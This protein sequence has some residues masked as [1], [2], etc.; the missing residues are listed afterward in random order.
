MVYLYTT[1]KVT[2]LLRLNKLVERLKNISVQ[3]YFPRLPT[4]EN[5][6]I[7]C[8][9]DAS[10]RNLPNEGSQAGFIIF[11]E[12]DAGHRR[13][14]IYWQSRKID[15]VV[16]STLAAE[17]LAL[18]DGAKTS[19]YLAALIKDMFKDAIIKVKCITDN[20]SLVDALESEKM[21]KDRWLR[22]HMLGINEM[23]V[24]GEVDKVQWTDSKNQ[25]ADALTKK[26]ICRDK[27]IHS[28]SRR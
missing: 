10:F 3:L 12:S 5:C 23:I 8:Y 1:A 24:K 6:T 18:H 22:L 7:T 2:D 11:L 9:T 19:I 16:D 21:V 25:L 13:C 20:K 4:L 14:P 27:L 26:G 15:R 17:T 28:I